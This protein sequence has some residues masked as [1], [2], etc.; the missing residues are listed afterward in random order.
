L[1]LKEYITRNVVQRILVITPAALVEQWR[2]ELAVKFGLPDFT[3]SAAPDKQ[4]ETQVEGL[5]TALRTEYGVGASKVHYY[6][7]RQDQA[8]DERKL[9]LPSQWRDAATL[10]RAREMFDQLA[11]RNARNRR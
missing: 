6:H 2:E 7:V 9:K 5:V 11:A 4:L 3:T 8:F 1:I 10:T